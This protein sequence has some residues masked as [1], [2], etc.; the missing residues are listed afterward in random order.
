MVLVE[1]FL[2]AVVLA[3]LV[4][5]WSVAPFDYFAKRNVAHVKP[6]PLLGNV[7]LAVMR[8]QGSY[9][10]HSIDLHLKLK[11][12]KV[13]GVYNM[14]EPLYYL[15]DPNLIRQVGIKSFDNFAN[16]RRGLSEANDSSVLS[17]SLLSLRDR[18]WKQMRSTLTPTFTSLKIRLM[19]ELIHACNLEAVEYI[20][21]EIQQ[22]E[23]NSELELKEFFTRYTN[24]VIAT[25]AFG[26][27]VNSFKDPQNEFY[28]IG[29]R[30]SQFTF[31]GGLKVALYI[32]LPKIMKALRVPVMDMNNV[33]YFK[34]LVFGTIKYRK[35]HNIIRPDMIQQLLEAQRQFKLEQESSEGLPASA[36]RAEFNDEDLLAQCLLFFSAGFETV[37]T[38][39]SFTSYE[40]HMNQ[41]VQQKLYEE[42]LEV[43]ERL[44]GKPLDYDTLMSMKY[45]DCIIS[46]SLRKWPPAIV[47]DRLCAENFDLVDE[48]EN[49]VLLKLQKEDL[50][51]IP[52][53]ALH[54]DPENFDEPNEFRPERFDEEHKHEIK[55]FSYLPFG[56]GQRSCIG[57]RMALMEVK[58]LIYQLIRNFKLEPSPRST[59]DMMNS[60]AG[61]RMQPRELF[62]CKIVAREKKN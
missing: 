26:V 36:D 8:G 30:V 4:Y 62:W 22:E 56:I 42:I 9:L 39:L 41:E 14:R 55:P 5:K 45:L 25:A 12:H 43:E 59:S 31:W 21:R 27:Q 34:K 7:P 23:S 17:K 32:L 50:V 58:S 57:N 2:L 38:C 40:L 53:I 20:G 16:H 24:D 46:E 44:E 18:R 10:K 47:I 29:Q 19:F 15:A 35:E 51:H 1:L 3:Y 33:E 37:A 49:K 11:Q 52:I 13:Y 6:K 61:F 48:D 28:T 60:I 54:Y